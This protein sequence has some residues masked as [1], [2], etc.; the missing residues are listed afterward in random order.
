MGST[1]HPKN[2]ST[3][4]FTH[5][6][7]LETIVG[8]VFYVQDHGMANALND[9]TMKPNWNSSLQYIPVIIY[10]MLGFEL[11]SASSDEM[12]N[13]ARDVPRAILASGFIIITLYTLAT[14]AILAA[15]PSVSWRRR[16]CWFLRFNKITNS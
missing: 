10:G 9:E 11:V 7:L 16:V 2:Y 6:H 3:L 4:N 1:S 8:A 12:E 15:I 5:S 13:P 14:I